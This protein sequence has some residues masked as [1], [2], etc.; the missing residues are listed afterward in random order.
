MKRLLIAA[1]LA[2]LVHA[3]WLRS[4]I[5]E[6]GQSSG[7]EPAASL[8]VS[9]GLGMRGPSTETRS[10]AS[11][12]S[13]ESAPVIPSSMIET[14]AN[15]S[16]RADA[17]VEEDVT[18]N[19]KELDP[20]AEL[21]TSPSTQPKTRARTEPDRLIPRPEPAR[22]A[23]GSRHSP[24]SGGMEADTGRIGSAPPR[25]AIQESGDLILNQPGGAMPHGGAD[26]ERDAPRTP[27]QAGVLREARPI[28]KRNPQPP[29]PRVARRR[30]YEG[31]VVVKALVGT[32]GLVDEVRLDESSG[33]EALDG[34]ALKTVRRWAFEPALRGDETVEMWV[35]IPL[36][37]SLDE[38]GLSYE[39]SMSRQY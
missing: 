21:P 1:L 16:S 25:A 5:G 24:D 8:V 23:S 12:D 29:Y 3:Y 30:G 28:Y 36:R 38:P 32:D 15:A 17:P 10:E 34:A 4:D 39:G 19:S 33:H 31:T 22:D 27:G 6:G 13:P 35:R 14:P 2:V 11:I 9:L 18:T 37:F 20:P 26:S 7:G